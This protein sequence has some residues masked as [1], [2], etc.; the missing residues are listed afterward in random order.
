MSFIEKTNNTLQNIESVKPTE[1]KYVLVLLNVAGDDFTASLWEDLPTNWEYLYGVFQ[2]HDPNK[3]RDA[4]SKGLLD[5]YRPILADPRPN[6]TYDQTSKIPDMIE[7]PSVSKLWKHGKR[8]GSLRSKKIQNAN[9]HKNSLSRKRNQ[10]VCENNN[11]YTDYTSD[12]SDNDP[13]FGD[14]VTWNNS[15]CQVRFDVFDRL[16]DLNCAVGIVRFLQEGYIESSNVK[17]SGVY[18]M[19]FVF[20]NK[21]NKKA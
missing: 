3:L 21:E 7:M 11:D 18:F 5:E 8:R 16:E 2:K 14:E 6:Q 9:D 13:D 1:K 17:S 10:D 20:E 19:R 15:V 12:D 4:K